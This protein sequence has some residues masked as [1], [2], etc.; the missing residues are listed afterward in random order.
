MRTGYCVICS[1]LLVCLLLFAFAGCGDDPTDEDSNPTSPL[2]INGII[3]TPKAPAPNDTVTLSV[4]VSSSTPNIG[5]IPSYSWSV[6]GGTLLDNNKS[7]VRW[8]ADAPSRIY[9][10]T[11]TVSNNIN[12][13]SYTE[14]VFVTN[15][16][17][18][19]PS[20]AGELKLLAGDDDFYFLSADE[21]AQ[22]QSFPGFTISQYDMGAVQAI[23][24]DHPGLDYVFSGDLSFA[25]HTY[26]L[27]SE[28]NAENSID[29]F[30]DE[31]PAGL[32][33]QITR[34]EASAQN[35]RKNQYTEP[36]IS[37]DNNLIAFQVF[38]ADIVLPE[39]GGVDTFNIHVYDV[40]TMET[41][42]IDSPYR[43]FYPAFSCD[44]QYLTFISNRNGIAGWELFAFPVVG[45]S[46]DTSQSALVQLSNTGELITTSNPPSEPLWA[47]NPNP[48]HPFLALVSG[49]NQLRL[50]GTDGTSDVVTGI[51]GTVSSMTW[52]SDGSR[53]AV[54]T[55]DGLYTVG[56]DRTAQLVHSGLEGDIIADIN[57][58]DND[59]MLIYNLQRL[60]STWFEIVNLSS[61]VD[62]S[63][64]LKVT[65]KYDAQG[66]EDYRKVCSMRPV[67]KTNAEIY[68]PQFYESTPGIL[69]MDLTG[70]FD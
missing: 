26:E 30:I 11:V 25:V 29:V 64:A 32:Q 20:S 45:G 4:T 18:L 68:L 47:W 55:G 56:L 60:S 1:V 49:D 6:S 46:V 37:P 22:N 38:K 40:N 70:I 65:P 52:S 35:R 62:L 3:V 59:R 36:C 24:N 39:Q 34:D 43:D 17:V 58:I 61:P 63:V 41:M 16:T 69:K 19:V 53:L 54:S 44:G 48:A 57:W 13:V 21:S 12:T 2:S 8:Y 66:I 14:P 7:L 31:L 51:A 5:D 67:W 28:L 23:T 33:T 42:R 10:V 50:V 27:F 15:S 9:D